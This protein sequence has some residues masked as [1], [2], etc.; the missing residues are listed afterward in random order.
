MNAKDPF[1]ERHRA[2]REVGRYTGYGLTW[3]LSVLLFLWI[4]YRLDGWLGTLP[5]FTIVGAFVGGAGG[6]LHLYK[7]LTKP[8]SR[9]PETK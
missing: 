8:A 9:D 4:G 1:E 5:L 3:A 6:F 2:T 7:G